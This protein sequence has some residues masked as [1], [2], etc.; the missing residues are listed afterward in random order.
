MWS[1]ARYLQER[2]RTKKGEQDKGTRT[3]AL[4]LRSCSPHCLSR[5]AVGL[6]CG[7]QSERS[8][9]RCFQSSVPS[10]V[11][12][13]YGTLR[14]PLQSVPRS[15]IQSTLPACRRASRSAAWGNGKAAKPGDF[16]DATF[17]RELD[18]AGFIHDLYQQ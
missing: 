16:V 6:K 18:K 12:A 8:R 14:S 9:D 3:F 13:T 1:L 2:F 17:V 5:S 4:H 15:P 11:P 7:F 10:G